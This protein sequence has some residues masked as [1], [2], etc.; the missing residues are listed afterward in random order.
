MNGER[1]DGFTTDAEERW[2]AGDSAQPPVAGERLPPRA[3]LL[4]PH[5]GAGGVQIEDERTVRVWVD[6]GGELRLR[7]RTG[8]T[9]TVAPAGSLHGCW[10]VLGAALP[11]VGLPASPGGWLVLA[12]PAGPALAL[13]L[14]DWAPPQLDPERADTVRAAGGQGLASALGADLEAVADPVEAAARVGPVDEALRFVLDPPLARGYAG[15][16][17]AMP[18]V[19][20][21]AYCV[22][23]TTITTAAATAVAVVLLALMPLFDLALLPGRYRRTAA[24]PSLAATWWPAQP[25]G[26]SRTGAGIGLVEGVAGVE[27]VMADGYGWEGWW[28]GPELGGAASLVV[29]SAGGHR[30]GLVL[31]DRD[32]R[33]LQVLALRDWAGRD[34]SVESLAA[35]GL[36]LPVSTAD[37]AETIQQAGR[38]LARRSAHYD[39]ATALGATVYTGIVCGLFFAAAL[40]ADLRAEQAV[41]LATGA[42]LLVLRLALRWRR[43]A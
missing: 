9:R 12:G 8:I 20:L 33:V 27:L 24:L 3:G 22:L 39:I 15:A 1:F 40:V 16:V 25:A 13:R 18:L 14:S 21:A 37:R 17:M 2:L 10:W 31:H 4:I 34:G 30:W 28:P 5:A 26:R 11:A 43:V 6:V 23:L 41:F 19:V 35:A 29:A 7:D 38:S 32:Q 36:G 42:A